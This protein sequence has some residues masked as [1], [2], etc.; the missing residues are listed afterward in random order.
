MP[1]GASALRRRRAGKENRLKNQ[2]GPCRVPIGAWSFG[3]F[4]TSEAPVVP[5]RLERVAA[6]TFQVLWCGFELG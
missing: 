1:G 5:I 6:L 2:E 4:A 3:V